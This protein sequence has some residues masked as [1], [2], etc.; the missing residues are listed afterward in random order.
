MVAVLAGARSTL[1]F[2]PSNFATKDAACK[3]RRHHIAVWKFC[4]RIGAGSK[5]MLEYVID[6]HSPITSFV[7]PKL[8]CRKSLGL[9]H[10]L[11]TSRIAQKQTAI[12]CFHADKS[13]QTK[14]HRQ[15][16]IA[17]ANAVTLPGTPSSMSKI[18]SSTD[19]TI[20]CTG[21]SFLPCVFPTLFV[22]PG[23]SWRSVA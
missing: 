4:A 6:Q 18:K 7:L 1:A 2:C 20:D 5:R 15:I 10:D 23:E 11:E 17:T 9:G 12:V 22:R 14:W 8:D 13:M 19:R 3:L 16:C 21:A